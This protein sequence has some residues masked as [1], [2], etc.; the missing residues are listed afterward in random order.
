MEAKHAPKPLALQA[1]AEPH[2]Y[3]MRCGSELFRILESGLVRCGGC[4]AHICNVR[5]NKPL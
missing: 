4:S 2:Y 3:C 5:C 1:G